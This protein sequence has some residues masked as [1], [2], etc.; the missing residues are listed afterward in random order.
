MSFWFSF[1]ESDIQRTQFQKYAFE[2]M[3]GKAA[4]AI[5]WFVGD[6]ETFRMTGIGC[7][8]SSPKILLIS[9]S[10][11]TQSAQMATSVSETFPT[12]PCLSC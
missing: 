8:Q 10:Q 12:S 9:Y 2:Y 4:G 7:F 1:D 5:A 3:P 11:V 6:E